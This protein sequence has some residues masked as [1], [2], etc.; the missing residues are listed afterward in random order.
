MR[1]T[2]LSFAIA[3]ALNL[4]V[5]VLAADSPLP[6]TASVVAGAT[7]ITSVEG[8]TEYRLANGLR[9]LLSPDAT[10]PSTTVNVTYLVGSRMENYGETGMAHLLEHMLFKGTPSLPGKSIPEQF[11][12]RGM[13]FNG[14]TTYDRTNYYETFASSDDN[15]DWALSMEADRMVNSFIARKDLDSEFSVVRNEMEA[16]ENNPMGVLIQKMN[17]SA[18]Q[19][20]NYGKSTI[21][22]RTDVENVSI[23]RL[24]DFYRKYYQPDNAVL[25][26][27][28]KFDEEKTLAA[29]VAKFGKIPRPT[30]IIEPTYTL[31]P[32]QDGAREVTLTRVGDNPLVAVEYHIA[33]GAH[34]DSAYIALLAQILGDEPSGR[35]YKTLVEGKKATATTAMPMSMKDPG[36]VIFVAL[37]NGKQSLPAAR[38]AML[39]ELENIA[40]KPITEAE[41]KRAKTTFLNGYEQS[42]SDPA[43]FGLALSE[44]I[45]KGDWRLFFLQR[46]RI[47]KATVADVQRVAVNYLRESNRTVGEFIPTAKP[48]RA[49]IPA[50]PDVKELVGSYQGRAK[51]AAGETFDPSAANI[52]AR[53]ER[54]TLD[55]GMKLALL[56]KSTRG[57]TVNGTL[58]LN[59]GDEKSL[60]KQSTIAAFTADMLL[61]GS[62]KLSRTEI[63]DRLR[64][65]N[66]NI[67]IGG[68]ASGISVH[69]ETRREHLPAL[70]KLLVEILRTP[71]FPANEL[72][73]LKNEQITA[74]EGARNDP[75]ALASQALS[76]HDNPYPKGD[77]RYAPTFEEQIASIKSVKPADLKAFHQRF[78]STQHAQL[79]L[80]G[81]F[82]KALTLA[83]LQQDFGHWKTASPYSRIPSPY[84]AEKSESITLQTPDKANAVW[85][86]Q[87][88]FPLKDTSPD[89]P[90]L[91]VATDILGGGALKNRLIDRLRQ[92]DGIS[93]GAGSSLAAGQHD[94]NGGISFYAIY[95]PQNLGRLKTGVS[96]E[97]A[98]LV[99]DG[100]TDEELATAKSGILQARRLSRAQDGNLAGL[101][102]SQLYLNR[103]MAFGTQLETAVK[104]ISRDEVNAVIRKYIKPD[105]LLNVYAGDFNKKAPAR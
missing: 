48:D 76:R 36:M 16:G 34:A 14:T 82:D 93:Y 8:I 4:S 63:E 97:L 27:T 88:N 92:K 1:L 23:D 96:E 105:Q 40:K 45:A 21:G 87:L 77:V 10:K 18:Y 84:I 80:V 33:P 95:A 9:V 66:A 71:S 5:P 70:L 68:G 59:M 31:D 28:G 50:A 11:S 46:D 37:L 55:N 3:A 67:S 73:S 38:A 62:G 90:G 47:E 39:A 19:W 60:F 72:D 17:A 64:S 7:R 89:F 103:T 6:A 104:N 35:L 83:Q 52:E 57:Q 51:Q 41:L 12:K 13:H 86:A 26:V 54:L 30:R 100:V 85:F 53:T 32:V 75:Q 78:Y 58:H 61:R 24:K 69:F 25:I 98:R 22:A 56:P 101:L 74:I 29:I 102:S 79:A 99:K 94:D 49:E 44:S 20:H 91:L 42:L 2:P 15:L 81:D 43:H 65:L